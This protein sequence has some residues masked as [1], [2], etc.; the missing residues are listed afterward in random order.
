[1]DIFGDTNSPI[2]TFP[3]SEDESILVLYDT[4]QNREIQRITQENKKRGISAALH[5]LIILSRNVYVLQ[6]TGI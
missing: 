5:Q 1:M 4:E 6:L 2:L 3:S